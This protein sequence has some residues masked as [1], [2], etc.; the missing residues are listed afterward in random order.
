MIEN[1]SDLKYV[2]DSVGKTA[3]WIC[4]LRSVSTAYY[5]LNYDGAADNLES[6]NQDFEN[7]A[8][9]YLKEKKDLFI[10]ND[11]RIAS[12][13]YPELKVFDPYSF[14]FISNLDTKEFI[15]EFYEQYFEEIYKLYCERQSKVGTI[16]P[17]SFSKEELKQIQIQ[18][19]KDNFHPI[20]SW[21]DLWTTHMIYGISFRTYLIDQ[22]FMNAY[23]QGIK[24]FVILG[25]GMDTRPLRM[26]LDSQCKVFELDFPSVL[27]FKQ[28]ALEPAIK[29]IKPASD[30]KINFCPCDL[31]DGNWIETIRSQGFDSE[32]STLWIAEGLLFYLDQSTI[33]KLG[34]IV[35]NNS[36][37][38][39]KFIIHTF[40]EK[41]LDSPCFNYKKDDSLKIDG[42][43]CKKYLDFTIDI[44]NREFLSNNGFSSNIEEHRE[45]GQSLISVYSIGTKL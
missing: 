45:I 21:V 4:A 40:V 9:A 3:L 8:I 5:C 25:S 6:N 24:Q 11:P 1:N 36:G 29:E 43:I 14:Y 12:I 42:N 7:R 20:Y 15:M 30:C 34:N 28:R 23:Q 19:F 18:K 44:D 38:K 31:S 10:P 16:H 32:R 13:V 17:R 39:S 41:S 26:P 27:S 37:A 35:N 33:T 22:M 2:L